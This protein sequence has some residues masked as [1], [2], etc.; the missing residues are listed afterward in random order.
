MERLKVISKGQQRLFYIKFA[1]NFL[2]LSFIA[3]AGV[4]VI[5]A[6]S[7]EIFIIY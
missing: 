6:N 7:Y 4:I 2:L 1:I 3:L 5:A